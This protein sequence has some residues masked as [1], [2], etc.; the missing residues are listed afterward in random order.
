M[1]EPAPVIPGRC[2][3]GADVPDQRRPCRACMDAALLRG[4]A[5]LAQLIAAERAGVK[6][7]VPSIEKTVKRAWKRTLPADWRRP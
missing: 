7:G 2:D 1:T 6:F 5:K 3:C 4:E